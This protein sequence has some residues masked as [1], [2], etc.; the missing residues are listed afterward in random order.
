MTAVRFRHAIIGVDDFAKFG[1]RPQQ[2]LKGMRRAHTADR[3]ISF[4]LD[5]PEWLYAEYLRND[6]AIAPRVEMYTAA[7]SGP[8]PRK[9]CVGEASYVRH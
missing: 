6:A 3:G 8:P 7:S 1:G 9:W 5:M 2:V 4:C